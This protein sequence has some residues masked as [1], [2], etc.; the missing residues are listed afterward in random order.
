MRNGRHV[1]LC[2]DDDRGFLNSM[3]SML[4]SAGCDVEIAAGVDE[5]LA[6]FRATRPDLVFVD[7]MMEEADSGLSFLRAIRDPGPTPPIYLLSGVGSDMKSL[8][9]FTE[10]GLT[11]VL[12]KPIDPVKLIPL[13]KAALSKTPEQ[14]GER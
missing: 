3:Q 5:G 1:V 7:L 6:K 10:M 14:T 9:D 13:V 11:D 4:E 8:A 2:I 12:Q